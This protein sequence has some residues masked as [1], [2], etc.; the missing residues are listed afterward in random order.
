MKLVDSDARISDP[1]VAAEEAWKIHNN[2]SE[3]YL[4]PGQKLP[5]TKQLEAASLQ[6][7]DMEQKKMQEGN[8]IQDLKQKV[9]ALQESISFMLGGDSEKE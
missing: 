9:H 6:L 8:I 1:N 4:R 2:A 7:D 5:T 3:M